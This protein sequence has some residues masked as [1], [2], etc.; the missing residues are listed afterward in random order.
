[1]PTFSEYYGNR[2]VQS[3]RINSGLVDVCKATGVPVSQIVE[4]CLGY[5]STL[6]DEMKID[7]LT[8]YDPDKLDV[9]RVH[10]PQMNLAEQATETARRE[11]GTQA[12]NMP[13]K[14]ILTVGLLLLGAAGLMAVTNGDAKEKKEEGK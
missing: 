9:Q 14:T 8:D 2:V 4:A 5:F 13:G 12:S 7:L 11:L 3:V 6:T 10:R 1:M